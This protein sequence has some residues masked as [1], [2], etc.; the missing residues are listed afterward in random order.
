L[1]EVRLAETEWLDQLGNGNK[2][3]LRTHR[4]IAPKAF[5]ADGPVQRSQMIGQFVER[6]DVPGP[7]GD[8]VHVT[9]E[10]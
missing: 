9:T 7:K 5:V 1:G 4:R 6:F 10:A 8:E 3:T 2:F